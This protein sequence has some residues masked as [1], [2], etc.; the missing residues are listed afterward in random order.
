MSVPNAR[1]ET[2]CE[3]SASY[4]QESMLMPRLVETII[5]FKA[6]GKRILICGTG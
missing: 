5:M 3:M 1:N 6:S 2:L 4:S